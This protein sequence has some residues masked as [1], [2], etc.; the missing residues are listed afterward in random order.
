MCP[1][2]H[3]LL[4]DP[5]DSRIAME[6]SQCKVAVH[7]RCLQGYI[8]VFPTFPL[9]HSKYILNSHLEVHIEK[10]LEYQPVPEIIE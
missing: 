3:T 4:K 2:L 10:K 1:Q 6:Y 5:K 8:S 9:V 7:L